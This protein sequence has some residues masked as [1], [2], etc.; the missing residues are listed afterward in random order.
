MPSTTVDAPAPT[1]PRTSHARRWTG[2]GWGFIAKLALMMLVNAFG[3]AAILSAVNAEAWGIMT[4]AIVLLVAADWIYFSKRAV[5]LKYIFP[6][7]VFLLVFQLFTMAYTGYV[8]FTNYGTGH[9]LSQEQAVDAVLIQNEKKVDG[10][11]S[12]PLTIIQDR[13]TLGFAIV[14]GDVV[15]AGTAE[16][17]LQEVPDATIEGGRATSVPGFEVI[18]TSD[19]YTNQQLQ[20]DVVVL[21]VPVSDDADEGSIR[22]QDATTGAIYRSTMVWDEGAQTFTNVDTGVVYVADSSVG[23]FVAEDGSTLPVGWHVVV[24]FDNFVKAFTDKNYSEAL[25]KVTAWTFAFAILTV[26]SSFFV[27]LILAIIFNDDRIRGR[28]I[29]RTLFILPYAFPAFMSALLWKGMLNRTYG[30]IN[31]WFLFG[32][33]VPWLSDPTMARVSVLMVNL[34]LSYPYWFLVCTGALQSLSKETMEASRIDGAGATRQFRSITLPLLLIS[35]APLAIASF[36]F[37][38]NNFT[39]IWMLTGGG[40]PMADSNTGLGYTDLLISAIYK[41]SGVQGGKADYGLASAL[42]ILVFIV[43]GVVSAIAFRQ[44]KKLEEF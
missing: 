23:S 19:I 43:V 11:P 44:T 28:K 22:T 34:W 41:I 14:D 2:I 42:S 4:A 1:P 10:S 15:K 37:N 35:T 40:P 26:L 39:I 31:D 32:L 33:D 25:L 24:G 6:G 8:A 5:P 30:V 27:G 18:P 7:L 3:L 13:G 16:Q 9:N 29:W 38:F 17:P 12:Y 20:K 36:A 21:R